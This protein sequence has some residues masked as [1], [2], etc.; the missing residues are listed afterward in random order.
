MELIRINRQKLKIMLTPS[1]MTHYHLNTQELEQDFGQAQGAF[2]RFLDD[3]RQKTDFAFDDRRISIQFFPSREGGC[4]LFLSSLL[5]PDGERED[6][7][8]RPNRSL[9]V[10]VRPSRGSDLGR[11]SAYRFTEI[12]HLLRV[13]ARLSRMGYI[14]KSEAWRDE[15]GFYYLLLHVQSPSLFSLP[16]ELAFLTEYGK[17]EN[18]AM[19]RIY[20]REHGSLIATPNAVERLSSLA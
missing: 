19:L 16:D 14:A 8:K 18:A 6:E 10:S 20:F 12:E 4:E 11:E 17:V 13:C 5:P 3:I 9:P 7:K 15:R 2:R 1:D